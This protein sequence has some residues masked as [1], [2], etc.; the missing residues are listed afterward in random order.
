MSKGNNYALSII[1]LVYCGKTYIPIDGAQPVAR[2]AMIVKDSGSN[3][4][5]TDKLHFEALL[6]TSILTAIQ[7]VIV[8]G[9]GVD[10]DADYPFSVIN[11][12]LEK[13][14]NSAEVYGFLETIKP[15]LNVDCVAAILYTSGSTG[16]PKGVQLSYL[17]L[18]N[19]IDWCREEL[20]VLEGDNFLNIA[21]FN[22]DLSTFDLFLSLRRGA[23]IYVTQESEQSNLA[24]ISS[25]VCDFSISV[26]YAVPT[27]LGMMNRV[28]VW[29]RPGFKNLN[30]IIYAGEVMQIPQLKFMINSL[31]KKTAVYNF[32]GPTE[33]NVCTYH[34]VAEGDLDRINP[35]P[36]GSPIKN[37]VAEIRNDTGVVGSDSDEIGE[38]WIGGA[39]VTPGYFNRFDEKNSENHKAGWHNTGDLGSYENGKLVYRG[40][41]DRMVKLNGYRV[42]LGE[43]ESVISLHPNV[44]EVAVVYCASS[45]RL[46]SHIVFKENSEILTLSNLKQF[47]PEHLPVYMIPHEVSVR[48]SLVKNSNGKVDYK[49][50]VQE[51]V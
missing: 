25:I 27:L 23:S 29:S 33:T 41:A 9:G 43:I 19:F 30:L 28:D 13:H 3:T 39:C 14:N 44:A 20:P 18:I 40:R 7:K 48:S 47:C 42:E 12:V 37:V 32:Y 22:F 46:K 49:S 50:L 45:K 8:M 35:V 24:S 31:P 36:I 2:A 38:I 51:L 16:M 21:N 34:R 6:E 15:L 4:I 17:N 11:F 1:S 26:I 10:V 5:I